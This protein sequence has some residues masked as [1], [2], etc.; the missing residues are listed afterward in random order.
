LREIPCKR[1]THLEESR[2]VSFVFIEG[3]RRDSNKIQSQGV[4]LLSDAPIKCELAR[5]RQLAAVPQEDWI[6][7]FAGTN[8]PV[9]S[10]T[11]AFSSEIFFPN[12]CFQ[13]LTYSIFEE[14]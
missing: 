8:S 9:L 2:C 5:T 1:P 4:A 6:R 11:D 12:F 7:L 3:T 10:P 13:R 14:R